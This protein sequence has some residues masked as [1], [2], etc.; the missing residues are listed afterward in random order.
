M[1]ACR[2]P[3]EQLPAAVGRPVPA[4][5]WPRTGAC[6]SC[7]RGGAVWTQPGD[8][9]KTVKHVKM[10]YETQ[11]VKFYIDETVPCLVNEWR[12]YI[13]SALFREYILKLLDLLKDNRP[14]NG[15]LNLLA[16]T[17][18]LEVLSPLDVEWVTQTVN[19]Q[20]IEHGAHFEAFL[21][22]I[23]KFGEMSV[24]RYIRQATNQ[25][26]FVIQMFDSL[27]DAKT[28]LRSV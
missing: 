27:D 28:W 18:K 24:D 13:T 23:D 3:S 8:K 22:P 20:Y 6:N 2:A 11:H 16:D 19:P 7:T 14:K 25:G 21:V 15:R 5:G 10:L 4:G 26:E 9:G 17:L 1:Q 12:G